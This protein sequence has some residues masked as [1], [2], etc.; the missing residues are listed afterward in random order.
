MYKRQVALPQGAD[1]ILKAELISHLVENVNVSCQLQLAGGN[2][3]VARLKAQNL[4]CIFFIADALPP[5]REEVEYCDL[6]PE[7]AEAYQ[8]FERTLKKAAQA[9]GAHFTTSVELRQ[10]RGKTK[11]K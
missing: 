2:I 10:G 7:L 11:R 5:Y 4:L 6:Q 9:M 1:D 3:G 8:A